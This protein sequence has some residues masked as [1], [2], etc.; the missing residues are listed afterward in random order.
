MAEFLRPNVSDERPLI[1]RMSFQPERDPAPIDAADV[2]QSFDDAERLAERVQRFNVPLEQIGA[3]DT[4]QWLLG[5]APSPLRVRF[6]K[7]GSPLELVTMIPW[8]VASY[9]G[10]WLLLAQIEK[11]WNMPKRI[12]VESKRLDAEAAEHERDELAAKIETLH[13]ADR[14]WRTRFG[15]SGRHM[16]GPLEAPGFRAVNGSLTDGEQEPQERPDYG[17]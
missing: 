8:S 16:Q 2:L 14:Y 1:L 6:V 11:F 15:T 4:P 9:G 10:V 17:F 7:F 5:G 13:L 12:K 3:I